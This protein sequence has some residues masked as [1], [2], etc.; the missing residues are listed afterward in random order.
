MTDTPSSG[1]RSPA[2]P[3]SGPNGVA[4]VKKA[5]VEA[6]CEIFRTRGDEI[7]LAERPRE[8]LILDSGVRLRTGGA[9]EIRIVVRAQKADFPNDEDAH[10]FDRARGAA[11]RAVAAGF[12]EVEATTTR[13]ADPGDPE[14]TLDTFYEVT[15]TKAAATLADAVVEVRFAL[16]LEKRA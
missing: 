1:P 15:F 3:S 8:N 14:R 13:V 6:G 7:V 9:L 12:V 5:L 2:A 11:A 16:S 4:Q 10:L